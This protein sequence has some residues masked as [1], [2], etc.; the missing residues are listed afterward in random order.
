MISHF[1]IKTID[2]N[3]HRFF[4]EDINYYDFDYDK[5]IVRFDF[6]DGSFIE[7]NKR[8][9]VYIEGITYNATNRPK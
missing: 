9:I 6:K 5:H 4:N 1:N 2:G 8:N 7:F 3:I